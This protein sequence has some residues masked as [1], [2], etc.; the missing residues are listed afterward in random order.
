MSPQKIKKNNSKAEGNDLQGKIK[1]GHVV[2]HS[3]RQCLMEGQGC[4]E[5]FQRGKQQRWRRI[6]SVKTK[7]NT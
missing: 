7:R 1:A 6:I 2:H 3:V 4:R 5:I